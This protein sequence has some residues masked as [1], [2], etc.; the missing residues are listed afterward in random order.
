MRQIPIEVIA[1]S[2][3]KRRFATPASNG[4]SKKI[5]ILLNLGSPN[6]VVSRQGGRLA[7]DALISWGECF[8]MAV[9]QSLPAR[10]VHV[11]TF[12]IFGSPQGL[13]N[14]CLPLSAGN[15]YGDIHLKCLRYVE[16]VCLKEG[17]AL[18][19]VIPTN[20][21]GTVSVELPPRND[22][23]INSALERLL[24]REVFKLNSDGNGLRDFLWIEDV[25]DALC[26]FILRLHGQSNEMYI[27]ASEKTLSVRDALNYLSQE[28]GEC[29]LNECYMWGLKTD[30][31]VPFTVSSGKLRDLTGDWRP[32][33]FSEAA[34][35]QK[36][37][38]TNL[39][40]D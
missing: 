15:T 10:C 8:L 24:K 4:Q 25:L 20:I 19:T 3:E 12:H 9:Q 31:V 32:K 29:I 37:I 34:K 36:I 7:E 21:Y 38:L 30:L 33:M 14:E 39:V 18:T 16:E 28:F 1:F 40:K 35:L 5:D 26:R 11:S 6:E 23:I 27:V 13:V 17:V 22:L 2:R